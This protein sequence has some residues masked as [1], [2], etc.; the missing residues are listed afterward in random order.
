MESPTIKRAE[1]ATVL[2]VTPGAKKIFQAIYRDQSAPNIAKDDRISKLRVSA[3]ISK[4]SFFYEKIRNAVN[5]QEDHLLRKDAIERILKRQLIIE[6]P[7]KM[8]SSNSHESSQ[9]LLMELIRAGYLANNSLPET[10]VDEVAVIIEKYF[11]LRRLAASTKAGNINFFGNNHK[12]KKSSKGFDATSWLVGLAA[13]EIE[14]NIVPDEVSR[15]VMKV[16]YDMLEKRLE[17]PD[18]LPYETDLKIQLYLA[19]HRSFL[20]FDD[21]MLSL[22]LINYFYG[23]WDEATPE[24]ITQVAQNF[25]SIRQSIEDQLE[26]PIATKILNI[27]SPYTVYFNILKDVI[28]EDPTKVYDEFFDDPKIFTRRIKSH[29]TK[30]YTKAKKKLWQ[31]AWRSILYIL[32]TKSIFAVILEV[33]AAQF[34]GEIVNPI[35]LGV[36]VLF[37]ALLLFF[38]VAVTGLPN[39]ENTKKITTGIEAIV[40]TEKRHND[41]I[42]IRK[43]IIRN[44]ATS[45]FFGLLYSVTFF[46]SFGAVIWLLR[47]FFFSWIS[48]IIFLF[49]LTFVSFFIIRVRRGAKEWIVIESRDTFLRFV[50][51]FFS[52]PIIATGKWLSGKFSQIN[53]FVFVLDFIIEAPFKVLVDVA[54]EWTKYVRERK[55]QI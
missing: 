8:T 9:H 17:L 40:F 35:T 39:E 4:V 42:I 37:P 24:L 25:S 26:H 5:Y 6:G 50:L 48:I 55:D 41:K 51:D 34:F 14:Q 31:A 47:T 13:V 20:K 11:T 18:T 19:I 16:M 15:T 44:P 7:I 21:D 30:R 28:S 46:I 45:I 54:E 52:T 3:V 12:K 32:L 33:P 29:C 2:T 10:K 43:P 27:V 49:F 38:A 23:G 36:N 22:I 1:E 53:I